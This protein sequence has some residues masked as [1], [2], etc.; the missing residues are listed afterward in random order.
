MK[1][2]KM[3]SV[4]TS[5]LSQLI[6]VQFL[7]PPGLGGL[8]KVVPDWIQIQTYVSVQ[9]RSFFLVVDGLKNF[10]WEIIGLFL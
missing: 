6:D 10:P 2:W 7:C 3:A 4:A 5:M 8:D 1:S 9:I